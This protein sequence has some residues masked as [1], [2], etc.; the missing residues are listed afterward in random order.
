MIA[1]LSIGD[2]ELLMLRRTQGRRSA[3]EAVFHTDMQRMDG[4]CQTPLQLARVDDR[5]DENFDEELALQVIEKGSAVH[6]I[7]AY[8]GDLLIMGSDG[9]F[10]NLF[11]DEILEII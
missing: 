6:C 7:S 10:D 9:T 11:L 1:V 5:I 3:F 8:E 2:C 4:N